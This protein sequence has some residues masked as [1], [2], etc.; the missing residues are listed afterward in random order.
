MSK[1]EILCT[2][3]YQTG[4]KKIEEM[5]IH[6]NV[7]FANQGEE[8][9]YRELSF[10]GQSAKMISTQTRGVGINR[11]LAIIHSSADICLFADDDM[12]Y[13]NG[14]E[15]KVVEA[16]SRLPK[17][18]VV[19]FGLN[20]IKGG[21]FYKRLQR[22]TG[23][24]PVFGALRY[25]TCTVAIRR[26]A[27][28]KN[29]IRFTHLFG[30]GGVYSHGEDSD[31]ILQCYKK[32]LRVYTYDYILGTTT[33]DSSTCFDGFNE[34]YFYDAGALA[35]HSFGFFAIPYMIYIGWRLGKNAT[36]SAKER[37]RCLIAGYKGFKKLVPYA[38]W[39]GK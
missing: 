26:E 4:W 13:D 29:N 36:I 2:T 39:K 24:L 27:L 38:E 35:R 7:V 1:F 30:G 33:K 19:I 9:S 8:T 32:G 25:G 3:M 5:N 21:K 31:F 37:Y 20:Y 23:K 6:T 18:D 34:K 15:E 28:L 17:A 22:K 16:F 14:L 10:E 11:N 12:M